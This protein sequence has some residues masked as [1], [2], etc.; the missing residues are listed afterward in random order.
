MYLGTSGSIGNQLL[1]YGG[2]AKDTNSNYW[3]VFA[4]YANINTTTAICFSPFNFSYQ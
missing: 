1:G 4:S 3:V 2:V